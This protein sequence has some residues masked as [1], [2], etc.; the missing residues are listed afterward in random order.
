MEVRLAT[1][2]TAV[3]GAVNGLRDALLEDRKLRETI[4][5]RETRLRVLEKRTG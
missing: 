3:V 2:L 5:D 1:E 4:A